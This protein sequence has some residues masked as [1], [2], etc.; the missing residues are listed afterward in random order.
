MITEAVSDSQVI[1]SMIPYIAGRRVNM[2]KK[3]QFSIHMLNDMYKY[4]YIAI[5]IICL[6]G[7]TGGF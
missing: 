6:Q 5:Y 7:G 1:S 4:N 3:T 2:Y